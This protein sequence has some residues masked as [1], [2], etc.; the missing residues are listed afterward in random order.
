MC[1]RLGP[2]AALGTY[3][4]LRRSDLGHY[5]LWLAGLNPDVFAMVRRSPLGDVL[6]DQRMF[7][8]VEMAVARY[9]ADRANH[10]RVEP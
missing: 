4:A 6:G 7:F 2:L 8:N 9:L 5:A 10:S 3:V 1:A